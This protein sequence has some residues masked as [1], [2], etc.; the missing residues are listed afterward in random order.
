M[1]V[2]INNSYENVKGINTI[3]LYSNIIFDDE[4]KPT[5]C[6]ENTLTKILKRYCDDKIINSDFIEYGIT[7]L[8]EKNKFKGDELIN[9]FS[10]ECRNMIGESVLDLSK[11]ESQCILPTL[12][13]E[14][15]NPTINYGFFGSKIIQKQELIVLE[16]PENVNYICLFEKDPSNV[17]E[18]NISL[19]L[20][21]QE[22][23]S[24]KIIFISLT[25]ETYPQST[26]NISYNIWRGDINANRNKNR[27][28]LR[29]DEYFGTKNSVS[30]V[31]KKEE[32]EDILKDNSS[33]VV[34]GYENKITSST[35]I[36]N[37]KIK[38]WKENNTY[39]PN[40]SYKLGDIV[41]YG[42][43]DNNT[44]NK[45][46]SLCNNNLSNN[47]IFSAKW[48]L[49]EAFNSFLT[50]KINIRVLPLPENSADIK[51]S[52]FL[53]V[54]KSTDIYTFY[55]YSKPGYELKTLNTE[56]VK[57]KQ[58]DDSYTDISNNSTVE[59]KRGYYELTIS[60]NNVWKDN[61]LKN[62]NIV[63]QLTEVPYTLKLNTYV[64]NTLSAT[65]DNSS[66]L[67]EISRDEGDTWQEVT[68]FVD[69]EG[70]DSSTLVRIVYSGLKEKHLE[71]KKPIAVIGVNS[72]GT[73][74]T[75]SIP[76]DVSDEGNYSIIDRIEYVGNTQYNT[77]ITK[78]IN[79][80]TVKGHLKYLEIEKVFIEVKY[81][82]RFNV[83]FYKAANYKPKFFTNPRVTLIPKST[84]EELVFKITSN[85]LIKPTT[86]ITPGLDLDTFDYFLDPS[87]EIYTFT[88]ISSEEF[89]IQ[90]KV[91]NDY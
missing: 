35:P 25:L 57:V 83:R 22:V 87:T 82:E 4:G 59:E 17:S 21:E 5:N 45:Y 88:G 11:V 68:N 33:D 46:I 20:D 44:P 10:E 75:K 49:E 24:S 62:R 67:V 19:I 56:Y 28:C 6:S 55:L 90:I 38:K 39:N 86:T 65:I 85:E 26:I 91:R 53:S 52:G 78:Q 16:A 51:P 41:N 89:E 23:S 84:G 14:S 8:I 29:N 31:G 1:N 43:D 73:L 32:K 42:L 13:S 7:T 76:F 79:K 15:S 74:T 60:G 63:F 70:I 72:E 3:H 2:L 81:G 77:Y 18:Y 61:I 71:I 69:I 64:E 48:V 36:L 58:E 9:Y 12:I 27:H 80:T 50:T 47:P 34:I 54:D 66:R 40:I 30:I 37:K